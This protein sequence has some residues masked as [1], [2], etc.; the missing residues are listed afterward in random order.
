MGNSLEKLMSHHGSDDLTE[1]INWF[2]EGEHYYHSLE[3]RLAQTENF[4]S[5][6]AEDISRERAELGQ[7]KAL[8]KDLSEKE[9]ETIMA[10]NESAIETCL[11]IL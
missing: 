3:R 5:D 2:V 8:E 10:D 7:Y 11:M 4:A 9:K 1:F 6:T